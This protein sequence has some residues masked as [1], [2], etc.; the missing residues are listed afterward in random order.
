[1]TINTVLEQSH[2][3]KLESFTE[4]TMWKHS[5]WVHVCMCI[6]TVSLTKSGMTIYSYSCKLIMNWNLATF[7]RTQNHTLGSFIATVNCLKTKDYRIQ[8]WYERRSTLFCEAFCLEVL[9][10]SAPRYTC[11]QTVTSTDI[12]PP[13]IQI[14]MYSDGYI[15]RRPPPDPDTHVFRQLHL[16]MSPLDSDT[17]VFRQL[18]LEMS[19]IDPDTHVFRQL[20]LQ[21]SHPI[22]IHMYSDSYIYRCPP[23]IQIHKYSDSYIY[24]RPPW[25]RYT[26]I[27][28]VNLQTSPL[29]PDTHVFRQC[30]LQTSPWSRYTFIQTVTSTDVPP[31]IQIHMYL[32][33]YIYRCPPLIQI[34]MYSDSYIY[35]YPPWSRYTFIQTVTSTDV[36]PPIQI[37][38]Y[39]DSYLQ[40]SLP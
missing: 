11:I 17:H 6:W 39:S 2:G 26:C 25:S 14:H 15:Y 32:D 3:L 35:R 38:I 1:M 30:Y 4:H 23:L 33:T 19:P 22:Q 18:H 7:S 20:H 9:A 8:S 10:E 21:T 12:P 29:D 24:R 5:C 16:Q 37:H 40:T 27:Q 31:P 13:P 34:H 36:P 28:T